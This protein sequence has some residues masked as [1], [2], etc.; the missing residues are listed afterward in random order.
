[1]PSAQAS[2]ARVLQHLGQS[3]GG[4]TPGPNRLIGHRE[5]GDQDRAAADLEEVR[6]RV[7]AGPAHRQLRHRQPFEEIGV[8]ALHPDRRAVR[9]PAEGL[10]VGL[11][12]AGGR[13]TRPA[14]GR[15]GRASPRRAATPSSPCAAGRVLAGRPPRSRARGVV[16]AERASSARR[17]AAPARELAGDEPGVAEPRRQLRRPRPLLLDA[18]EARIG[19]HEDGIERGERGA[20]ALGRRGGPAGPSSKRV[21]R[22]TSRTE[23]TTLTPACAARAASMSARNSASISHLLNGKCS[24]TT[25]SGD[26][27]AR[28]SATSR[29]ARSRSTSGSV[30]GGRRAPRA[31]RPPGRHAGSRRTS[32]H[33]A[34]R[35]AG[36]G[37]PPSTR[38]TSCRAPRARAISR[39]RTKWPTP[40]SDCTWLR[41]FNAAPPSAVADPQPRGRPRQQSRRRCQQ[42][43]A[44]L[45]P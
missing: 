33:R 6:T 18:Q 42:Q 2:G 31:G 43:R 8:E 13:E 22:V 7:V 5:I 26:R 1:M 17:L 19:V 25:T 15:G 24:M 37:Q 40:V 34:R 4:E 9:E 36:T 23:H 20:H 35:R 21:F 44:D 38:R 39:P 45:G 27:S 3:E 28:A 32:L 30:S 29:A 12:R 41:I 10:D 11:A 14:A 16:G